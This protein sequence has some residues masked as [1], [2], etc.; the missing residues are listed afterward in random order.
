MTVRRNDAEEAVL[1]AGMQN[2]NAYGFCVSKRSVPAGFR[3]YGYCSG[4]SGC[5]WFVRME[6]D[7]VT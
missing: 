6:D 3:H 7:A 1:K 2:Q 5:G 4:N